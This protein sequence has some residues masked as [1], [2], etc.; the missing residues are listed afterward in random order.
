[1]RCRHKDG[2]TPLHVAMPSIHR[3][4]ELSRTPKDARPHTIDELENSFAH[5]EETADR[6]EG[7]AR[8]RVVDTREVRDGG[9]AKRKDGLPLAAA[10]Q[11]TVSV[12]NRLTA[13]TLKSHLHHRVTVPQ[14]EHS[15]IHVDGTGLFPA[16]RSPGS[17]LPYQSSP[18]EAGGKDGH[19]RF[20]EEV[21]RVGGDEGWVR[22]WRY[23]ANV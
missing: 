6:R 12:F 19:G 16:M 10:D 7:R 21:G 20:K 22:V 4:P 15:W 5:S 23:E 13:I 3:S 17:H 1:M 2:R 14:H 18:S 9:G 8:S 11:N